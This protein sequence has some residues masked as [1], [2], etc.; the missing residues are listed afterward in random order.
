MKVTLRV[1]LAEIGSVAVEDYDAV[2]SRVS[3]AVGFVG[4]AFI[5]VGGA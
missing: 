5:F 1:E 4:I 3:G 2:T